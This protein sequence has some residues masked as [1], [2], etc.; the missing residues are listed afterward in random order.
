M[1]KILFFIC[2]LSLLTA[3]FASCSDEEANPTFSKREYVFCRFDVHQYA[4]LFNVM[5]T[6]DSLPASESEL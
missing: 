3:I 2:V 6:T 5:A 1:K 4:E